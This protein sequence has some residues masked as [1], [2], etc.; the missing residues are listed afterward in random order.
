MLRVALLT[1]AVGEQPSGGG[2]PPSPSSFA[3]GGAAK[4]HLGQVTMQLSPSESRALSTREI[5]SMWREA[6]GPIADAV[7]LKFNAN[8][9]SVGNDID[10]QLEGDNVDE[11]RN[12]LI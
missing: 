2:G 12:A 11:L 9:F 3:G 6:N 10:I 4:G 7:E 8:L 5:A 1:S